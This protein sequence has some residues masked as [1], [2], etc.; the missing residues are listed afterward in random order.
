MAK[1]RDL[2]PHIGI[3][4]RRNNGKSSLIN[5]ITNQEVAIV[6]D[7]PG[8]TTD[9]VKKSLEISGIGPAIIVDTAGIDDTGELGE[10]RIKK[11]YDAI[12]TIDCAILV[13]TQNKF[14]SFEKELIK[15]FRDY[16]IPYFIVHNKADI[17]PLEALTI[18]RVKD[19]SKA[20]VLD[21]SVLGKANANELIAL[22]KKT[23]PETT[24][25]KPSLLGGVIKPNGV[26]LLV[27][28]ID[29]AA[30]EGRM[31]LPQ[32][33]SIRDVLDNDNICI[34]LKETHL[35][36]YFD[37]HS[38]EPKLVITDSQAFDFVNK[39]V[40]AHIPLTSFS[41]VFARLKGDFEQYMQG[42]PTLS[43]LNDGDKILILES[44]SHHVSCEDIGRQKLPAWISKFSGKQLE[45]DVVAGLSD[46]PEINNYKMVIQCGGCVVTRKQL[47]NRLRPAVDANIAVSNYGMSIAWINGI[48]DR[49]IAPFKNIAHND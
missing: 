1:G 35:Q 10:K 33:M 17:E 12:K 13:I 42:T 44:C 43:E 18:E 22:L 20:E 8:T 39:I 38:P 46:I 24:Y 11:T 4:G 29:A 9:P 34:V 31:I 19:F 45:F 36:Q 49:V 32:V 30:P 6:S 3:F 27:T 14:G 41:I 16:S 23:I 25:Q 37:Q 40:P 47:L 7:S 15:Q 28:P 5:L 48:F 2:K 21:F 26:I